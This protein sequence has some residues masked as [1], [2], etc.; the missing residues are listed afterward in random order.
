MAHNTIVIDLNRCIGCMGC[1]TACKTVNS[2]PIG[3]YWNRIVRVGPFPSYE[4]AN[5]PDVDWYYLPVQCQH[6]E[7]APCVNVC[8][9]GASFKAEDGTVQVDP[10]SCIGCQSC[11]P[12]CPYGVRY[13]NE[14]SLVVEKCTMCKDITA[15]GG[16]PQCVSQCAGLAKWYGDLDDDPT[17]LSFRGG[18]ELTLGEACMPFTEDEVHTVPDSGN[19]PSIRYILRGKAWQDDVDVT[20]VQGGHGMGLPNR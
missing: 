7:D 2:V 1:N 18:D 14:E 9:T 10:E 5:F 12:V 17:M 11:V 16:I 15:E 19:H 6:C 8:P 4:G 20:L 13:M 3:N